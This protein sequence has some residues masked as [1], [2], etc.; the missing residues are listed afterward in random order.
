PSTGNAPAP[1][2]AAA[3]GAG[4]SGSC[5]YGTLR[6]APSSTGFQYCLSNGSWGEVYACGG[7]TKCLG[8]GDIYCGYE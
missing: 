3:A 7:G 1:S 4:S 6:C 2:S 5:T 8:T